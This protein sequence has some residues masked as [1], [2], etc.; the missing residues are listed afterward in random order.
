MGS[1]P[2]RKQ[3][4]LYPSYE[5]SPDGDVYNIKTGMLKCVYKRPDGYLSVTLNRKPVLVHQLVMRTFNGDPPDDGRTFTVD[6]I[7]R[8]R[9]NNHVGNLRWADAR[10]QWANSAL[11]LTGKTRPCVFR[12]IQSTHV[13]TGVITEYARVTHGAKAVADAVPGANQL[14]VQRSI[15]SALN[16]GA[17]KYGCKWAYVLPVPDAFT[18]I[19][20]DLVRGAVGYAV[21]KSGTVR[22]PTGTVTR[23]ARRVGSAYAVINIQ[24]HEYRV[25]RL[26]LGTFTALDESRP[27]V[28][29]ING[30]TT[31][32]RLENLRWT[33]AGETT[34]VAIANGLVRRT[35]GVRVVQLDAMNGAV[36][37]T[38]D[39]VQ[40][41]ARAAGAG[42]GRANI[43]ACCKG[44][45][46]T[47]YGY[48]WRYQE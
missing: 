10:E 8:V 37:A 17:I 33:R 32:N 16:T 39:S 44:R 29:H 24:R 15:Y 13:D 47:A 7:D 2:G 46:K 42:Y 19:P 22:T 9:H 36:V 26:V 21:S 11:A 25:H 30:D 4:V 48:R 14:T 28:H 40:D 5:I 31:D 3:L 12:A 20:Q 18:P 35:P 43:T 38:H 27:F 6:H 1:A 41:A 23:G 34:A 45:Q